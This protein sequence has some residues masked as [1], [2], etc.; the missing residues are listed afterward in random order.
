MPSPFSGMDKEENIMA[1]VA[2]LLVVVSDTA[3]TL[4]QDHRPTAGEVSAAAYESIQ[5]AIAASPGKMVLV[6]GR[7]CR[8]SH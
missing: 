4:P 2:V 5:Q 8:M 3:D 1:F 6:S 7:G